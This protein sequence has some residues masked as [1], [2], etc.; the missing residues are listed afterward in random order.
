MEEQQPVQLRLGQLNHGA[1]L[2]HYLRK[3][4]MFVLE[5]A[6]EDQLTN[7]TKPKQVKKFKRVTSSLIKGKFGELG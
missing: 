5:A 2:S 4:Q 6:V 3:L 1:R 7:T